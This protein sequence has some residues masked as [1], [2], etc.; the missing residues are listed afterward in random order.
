MLLL[1][2]GRFEALDG[3][4]GL[5]A[6][7]VVLFHRRDWF[8]G[9]AFFGHA[10]LAVD[11]FFMLS[12]FVI[13]LAYEKRL[14]E[15]SYFWPYVRERMIRLQPLL[16]LGAVLGSIVLILAISTGK[17]PAPE[18]AP[19]VFLFGFVPLPA[20]WTTEAF[21]FPV[22]PPTWSLFWEIVANLIFGLVAPLL[23]T[24]VLV[25]IVLSLA[26]AMIGVSVWAPGFEVGFT[27]GRLIPGLP[28]VCL[29]FFIGVLLLR[30]YRS[31]RFPRVKI[32][33]IGAA[34]LLASLVAL[35]L[36]HA[37]SAVYDPLVVLVLYP[38]IVLWT[39]DQEPMFPRLAKFSGEL[40][41]PLYVL[42][43]PLLRLASGALIVTQISIAPSIAE[44]LLRILFVTILCYIALKIY[45]EPVRAWLRPRFGANL[46]LPVL[47][48]AARMAAP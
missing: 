34:L 17:E 35:P 36:H 5:A 25:I 9:D 18:L 4:R 47:P 46:T 23:R 6:V 10:Y 42:H 22:N 12:G 3:L 16:L 11:F 13:A 29:S 43:E 37:W 27:Q 20:F 39:A 21:A 2:R 40:S 26:L 32:R 38:L 45:D 33:G 1:M 24:R 30:V 8:G 19:L 44:G 31:G 48:E 14:A 41:Y 15:P 28:R 7:A